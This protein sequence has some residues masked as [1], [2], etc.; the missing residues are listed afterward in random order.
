MKRNLII[1]C[2][3]VILLILFRID[4]ARN[5]C[6]K[7]F[8]GKKHKTFNYIYDSPE[9]ENYK[10]EKIIDGQIYFIMFDEINEN[11]LVKTDEKT[12]LEHSLWKINNKGIII[13][14]I[15]SQGSF[16]HSGVYFHED[17]CIDWIISGDKSKKHYDKIITY[18]TLT[19]TSFE[20]L[21]ENSSIVDFDKKHGEYNNSDR[22]NKGRC[23]IKIKEKWMVIE[24]EK[25]FDEL[26]R[27]YT[28][29]FYQI[30]HKKHKK[31]N[32]NRLNPIA[33]SIPP[34]YKWN[35]Q[36]NFIHKQKFVREQYKSSSF[37]DINNTSRSGWDGT[38]FFNLKHHSENLNFKAFGF[39][40]TSFLGY[41]DNGSFSPDISIYFAN[42]RNNNKKK[43]DLIFIEMGNLGQFRGRNNQ[44]IGLYIVKKK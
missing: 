25:M 15:K 29:T 39:Q 42:N 38:G 9:S 27:D 14:S 6:D 24:S 26:E 18:D 1:I 33:N 37:Y 44:E 20:S 2:S 5:F 41:I 3:A 8:L 28:K 34:F 31:K 7:L 11:F 12:S 10:I 13:D 30:I 17:Y 43:I 32:G 21:L 22:P 4:F 19:K 35:N 36:D 40:Y 23:F 16:L